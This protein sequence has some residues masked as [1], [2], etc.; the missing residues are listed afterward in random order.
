[1]TPG[2][3]AGLGSDS[4]NATSPSLLLTMRLHRF[5]SLLLPLA[6]AAC[7]SSTTEP[8]LVTVEQTTFA[9]SL[10]VDLASSTKTAS[11]LYYKDVTVG[12]G[13]TLTPGQLVGVYYDGY[14][15]DG[16][17]F[18]HR[19]PADSTTPPA[20]PFSFTL[21]RG[22]VIAGFDEGVTGMKIGGRRQLIIPPALGYGTQVNTVL[23]FTVDAVSAQ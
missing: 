8:T 7:L 22:Q 11:G 21:G 12:T 4:R 3:A 13:A 23:V 18:D 15:A 2:G 17:H 20:T 10:G 5:S 14:Y 19:L 16:T 6:F 9:P 1:V